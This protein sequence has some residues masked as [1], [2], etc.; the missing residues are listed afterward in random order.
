[1]K[2]RK[3]LQIGPSCRDFQDRFSIEFDKNLQKL[4]PLKRK[5]EITDHLIDQIV[6]KLYGLTEKE[7]KNRGG[8]TKKMKFKVLAVDSRIIG[9]SS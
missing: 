9:G 8:K 4:T 6:Y 2:N 5:I 7:N 3:T 1:M